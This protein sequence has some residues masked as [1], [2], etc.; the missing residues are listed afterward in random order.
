MKTTFLIITAMMVLSFNAFSQ[1][2]KVEIGKDSLAQSIKDTTTI[3][4][5]LGY[6]NILKERN[7][8][9]ISKID[10]DDIYVNIN[11]SITETIQGRAAG[12]RVL[13][14]A[15]NGILSKLQIRGIGTIYGS[16]DPLYVV[17]GMVV[18]A[19]N[20]QYINPSD[21]SSIDVLK[22]ASACAI[23][24]SRGANGVVVIT[25]KRR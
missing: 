21:V 1:K 12:V 14:N 23:Y 16:T 13:P 4:Y 2:N 3:S 5:N 18:S 8:E 11:R 17:D 24:G 9:S 25:T 6:Y 10:I 15:N 7:I 19:D 20:L 22:D